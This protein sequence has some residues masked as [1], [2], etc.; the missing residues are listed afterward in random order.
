MGRVKIN[1]KALKWAREEAGYDYSN[2]P[3]KIKPKFEE[4]ES[5]KTMPTWK[6]LC[7]ISKYFKR[8]SAFFFRKN[9]PEHLTLDFIEYRKLDNFECQIKSPN[10]TLGIHDAI[11]KRDMYIELL[12]D[13]YYPKTS[14]SKFKLNSNNVYILANHIRNIL[15]VDLEEQKS[16]LYVNNRKNAQH[17][18]FLNQWKDKLS[19]ELGILIFEVPRVSLDEMRALCIYYDEYPIIL[20]NSADSPNARIFSLFHELTH[21]LLGESAICDVDKN[22]SKEWLCNSVAAQFLIPKEDLLNK[23]VV[24]NNIAKEWTNKELWDLSNEYG[25]SKHSILLR[26]INLN[27]AHQESYDIFKREWDE[28]FKKEKDKKSGGGGNPVRNQV[29]YNGKLYSSLLLS[30]YEAGVLSSVEFSQGIG[31]RL[32]HVN[33]LSEQLFG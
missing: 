4:W 8:P 3:N 19:E 27:K 7:D 22:N 5:G 14:F 30:A 20:L 21:L 9:L 10:L 17:Y 16:W 12:E 26:L 24:K 23:T 13:M 33:E 18:N 11:A 25:V 2:L 31:L 28:D 1:P 15:N 6:Q 29:K 32:K